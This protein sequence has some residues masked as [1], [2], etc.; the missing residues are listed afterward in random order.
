MIKNKF[1]VAADEEDDDEIEMP[2]FKDKEEPIDEEEE[3][4]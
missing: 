3:I 2:P 1:A 4:E